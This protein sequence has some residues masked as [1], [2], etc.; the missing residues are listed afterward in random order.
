MT[1]IELTLWPEWLMCAFLQVSK[2]PMR[3]KRTEH[4]LQLT[5]LLSK[6]NSAKLLVL[7]W[8]WILFMCIF[9][10]SHQCVNR[11]SVW[12]PPETSSGPPTPALLAFMSLVRKVFLSLSVCVCLNVH[13]MLFFTFLSL[14]G[15]WPDGSDGTDINASCR[16]ND[17]S[18]LVT[19]DDF[20]KVHLFSH[21]CSQFR[22]RPCLLSWKKIGQISVRCAFDWIS[23]FFPGS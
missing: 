20:G 15:L 9:Q 21:P 14:L 11:W 12:K 17:K 18:L 19:G 6:M 1:L 16:S 4:Q 13:L 7:T 3:Q 2:T 8:L 22:V 10:G 5:P 23:V